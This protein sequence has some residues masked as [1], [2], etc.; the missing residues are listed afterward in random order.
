[1]VGAGAVT[2]SIAINSTYTKAQRA[3]FCAKGGLTQ[4][5]GRSRGGWTTKLHAGT[6]VIG[7][8]Y[9]LMRTASNVSDIKAAP[10]LI[11][12]AGRMRYLP[13]EK[14]Q[15]SDRLRRDAGAVPVIHSRR[16]AAHHPLRKVGYGD[17]HL[18]E[19]AFCRLKEFAASL[20]ATINSPPISSQEWPSPPLSPSGCERVRGRRFGVRGSVRIVE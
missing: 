18:I 20:P 12:R 17:R 8:P 5:I 16:T 6:D 1:V 7:R 9:A 2:R 14:A 15:D 13:T 11:Q 3:A 10:A 4:A 19:N